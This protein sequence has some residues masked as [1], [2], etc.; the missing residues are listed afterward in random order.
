MADI[1][2]NV[3]VRENTGTGGARADRRLGLVPGILY[4]GNL[5]NVPISLNGNEVRKA[6]NSGEFINSTITIEHK[7]DKQLVITRDVQFHPVSEKAVHVDLYRVDADQIIEM[8]V[9]VHFINH[10]E[11]PG[12]KKGG[13]LNVVRHDIALLCP[14]GNIP[15][16]IEIDL[17]GMDIGDS[18][19]ISEIKLPKGIE[20]AITDR[21]FTIVT[22][23]GSRAAVVEAEEAADE[24][25]A[26]E[27][28]AAAA[29]EE[30]EAASD[31]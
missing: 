22:V 23:T 4:G 19:H 1:C 27:A 5:G 26:A 15:S 25:A 14:A 18:V 30:G 2:L 8:D 17:T 31:E 3:E 11:A 10:E 29:A 9:A 16:A 28:A 6:I 20:S 13:A 21:D 12:L 24:A 7:G